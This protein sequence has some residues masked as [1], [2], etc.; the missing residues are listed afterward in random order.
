MRYP[1][2]HNH[3]HY[4]P[5]DNHPHDHHVAPNPHDHDHLVCNHL[6][7]QVVEPVGEVEDGE[8]EREDEPADHVDPLGAAEHEDREEDDDVDDGDIDDNYTA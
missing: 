8:E 2:N 3:R 1:H 5:H 7:K 4:H 6:G